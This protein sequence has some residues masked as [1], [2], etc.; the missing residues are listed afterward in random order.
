MKLAA[1]LTTMFNEVPFLD[2]FAAAADA[3]FDAVEFL[4][5]YDHPPE[6]VARR[7]REA[8]TSVVLFN[9]P[10]GDWDAG[11]RG[12]A[13][14]HAGGRKIVESI[15]TAI[16]YA[17]ALSCG[18]LHVMAGVSGTR[19]NYRTSIDTAVALLDRHGIRTLIEPINPRSMPGYVMNDFDHAADLVRH[20][21]NGPLKLQFDVF[22]RQLICGDILHGIDT[23]FDLIGH[24]QIS[25][26]PTRHEPDEGEVDYGAVLRHLDHKRYAGFIGCEYF[27]RGATVEGLAWAKPYLGQA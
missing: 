22:H 9:A 4:F 17:E 13:A 19:D 24:I 7:A 1:N 3:G 8:G 27:P 5:P 10:P 15:E 11:D 14:L 12:I 23:L 2:R 26:V 18:Q 16:R 6:T 20:F 21:G 25:G